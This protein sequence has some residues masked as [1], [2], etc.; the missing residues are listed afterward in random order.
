MYKRSCTLLWSRAWSCRQCHT[1]NHHG[2]KTCTVNRCPCGSNQ[3][4][5]KSTRAWAWH[6][7]AA[8]THLSSW[9]CRPPQ[10]VWSWGYTS[11]EAPLLPRSSWD[12]VSKRF[13]SLHFMRSTV[14]LIGLTIHSGKRGLE[15]HMPTAT[16][17]NLREGIRW[18][19]ACR[20]GWGVRK[21]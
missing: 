13:R 16:W 20:R 2:Y 4:S 19:W 14:S 6:H 15:R 5:P 8:E 10:H 1:S 21:G 18:H 17:A 9:R 11:H 7:P 3:T 12:L